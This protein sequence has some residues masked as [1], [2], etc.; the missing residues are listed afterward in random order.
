M[1]DSL[2]TIGHVKST[3]LDLIIRFGPKLVAA[4][5]ILAIGIVVSRWLS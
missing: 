2:S 1:N 4:I 3:I 5:L